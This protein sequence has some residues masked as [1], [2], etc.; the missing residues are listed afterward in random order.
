MKQTRGTRYR[1]PLVKP[2]SLQKAGSACRFYCL[3]TT[4]R[5]INGRLQ[6]IQRLVNRL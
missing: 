2:A 4:G 6:E 1:V 5:R 3:Q